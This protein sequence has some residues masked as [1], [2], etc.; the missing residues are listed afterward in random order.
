MENET[1]VPSNFGRYMAIAEYILYSRDSSNS[2]AEFTTLALTQPTVFFVQ[3]IKRINTGL[4]QRGRAFTTTKGT[5][6][7]RVVNDILEETIASFPAEGLPA[8]F[9]LDEQSTIMINYHKQKNELYETIE[10]Y[11]TINE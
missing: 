4:S 1:N 10:S 7:Y 11:E 5:R 8:Q 6:R 9:T 2:L 3:T